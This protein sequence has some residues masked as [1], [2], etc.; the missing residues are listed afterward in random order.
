MLEV[1][2]LKLLVVASV[3]PNLCINDL[4]QNAA[5]QAALEVTVQNAFDMMLLF[6]K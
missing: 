3:I 5:L 4:S 1:L 6:L 2:H